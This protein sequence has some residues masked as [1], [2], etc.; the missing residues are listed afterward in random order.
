MATKLGIYN[1][2]LSA[3]GERR[4][5]ALNADNENRRKLDNI[6]NDVLVQCIEDGP[7]KGWK[8]TTATNIGVDRESTDIVSF[9]DYASTVT[10]TVKVTTKSLHNLIS[11]NDVAIDSTTSYDGDHTQVVVLSPTQFYI[12]DTFVADDATGDLYWISDN[13][14]YRYKI[15]DEAERVKSVK[16]GGSELTDWFEEDGYILTNSEDETVYMDYIKKVKNTGLFPFYF[17]KYLYLSL[18]VELSYAITK[19]KTK[20]ER[21]EGKLEKARLKAIGLDEQK[22][23]VEEVST[24]WVDAGR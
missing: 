9:A 20:T 8:F 22:K 10:G 19:S 18:A 1:L 21:L 16:V 2:T 7:E 14:R 3:I 15:P 23:H 24:S 4:L 5:A 12:T 6:Y 17:T 13:Y 11:G